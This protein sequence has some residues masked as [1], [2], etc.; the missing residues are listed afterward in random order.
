MAKPMH[1]R[2]PW[3]S[4]PHGAPRLTGPPRGAPDFAPLDPG[5]RT[6]RPLYFNSGASDVWNVISDALE[7]YYRIEQ[8]DKLPGQAFV[9]TA[10]RHSYVYEIYLTL[11]VTIDGP[12]WTVHK[13]QRV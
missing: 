5:P 4:K 11:D 3:H 1:R 6:D 13:V 10:V 12:V 2:P 9:V 8:I 7:P